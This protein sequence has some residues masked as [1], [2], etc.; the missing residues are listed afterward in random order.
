MCPYNLSYKYIQINTKI[1][2]VLFMHQVNMYVYL[3]IIVVNTIM[4]SIITVVITFRNWQVSL[5]NYFFKINM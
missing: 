4:I 5:I 1:F 3:I 2:L